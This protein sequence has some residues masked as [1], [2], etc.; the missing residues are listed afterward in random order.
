MDKTLTGSD[1][2]RQIARLRSLSDLI[3]D[4]RL[5]ALHAAA[6]ARADS[7]E[8]LADLERP[9]TATDLPD[10]SAAE[11]WMRYQG[12]ADQRRAE[13]NLTLAW[14]TAEWIEA[15]QAASLAFGK[16]Q[17]LKGIAKNVK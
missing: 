9:V 7:L 13:I 2:F 12:W 10:I 14:Q 5:S 1:K 15:R 4:A 8:R 11:V 17:A 16:L 3:F 6:A